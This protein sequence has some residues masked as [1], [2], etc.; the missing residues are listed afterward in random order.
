MFEGTVSS[1]IL[2]ESW[3]SIMT[4][5]GLNGEYS[6]DG[7]IVAGGL[8]TARQ[9]LRSANSIIIIAQKEGGA[10]ERININAPQAVDRGE[11]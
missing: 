6:M 4:R 5:S 7:G 1:R 10:W 8:S 3:L 9:P 11:G 2:M